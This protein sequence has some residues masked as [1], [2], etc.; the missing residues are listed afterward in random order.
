MLFVDPLAHSVAVSGP[1][2][3]SVDDLALAYYVM[4]GKDPKVRNL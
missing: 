1:M 4:A 2:A 3:A